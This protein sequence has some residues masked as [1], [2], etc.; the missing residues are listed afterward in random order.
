MD[1]FEGAIMGSA[2]GDAFGY[3]LMKLSFDEI[4]GTFEKK[5]AMELAVNRDRKSVV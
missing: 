4:C 3:P 2:I 1:K 5:G